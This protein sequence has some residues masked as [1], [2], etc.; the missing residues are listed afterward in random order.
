METPL[1]GLAVVVALGLHLR[2]RGGDGRASLAPLTG[3]ACGVAALAR[4]DAALLF[5][6]LGVDRVAGARH[7]PRRLLAFAAPFVLLF[8]GWWAARWSWYG[9][10]W[11]NPFVVKVGATGDQLLRGL[12]HLGSVA[13]VAAPTGLLLLGATW[14]ARLQARNPGLWGVLGYTLLHL[15]YVVVV[16]GDV[17]WGWRFFAVVLLPMAL[18]GAAAV[19][20]LAESVDR[21]GWVGAGAAALCGL[22]LAGAA[23]HPHLHHRGW[24][25]RVGLEVGSWL[26]DHAPDD[27]LVATNIAGS[28]PYASGLPAL[29]TL[30]LNDA[31]IARRAVSDMG[32]GRAGHEKGDG[33]YV[34]SRQPDIVILAS[35]L[36]GSRPKFRGDRELLSLDAFHE[37]YRFERYVLPGGE[38]LGLW[39]RRP[40]VGGRP[41]VGVT[42]VMVMEDT[43]PGDRP[44][45]EPP[46]DD[47]ELLDPAGSGPHRGPG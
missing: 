36:G 14:R 33:A 19:A 25:A 12:H 28:I 13:V 20:D 35:S 45:P 11:P 39:V 31:H 22:Q 34:L 43:A 18:L 24:V 7:P 42:P 27:A 6:A 40:E 9:W 17:F 2:E 15:L 44:D 10:F 21:P 29:D 47:P 46:P 38:R 41:L 23:S 4:P 3:L 37:Q 16:G 30:G 26:R 1:V 5:V 32:R 8:G